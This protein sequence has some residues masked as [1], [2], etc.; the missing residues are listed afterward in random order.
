MNAFGQMMITA[1]TL[2]DAVEPH[3]IWKRLFCSMMVAL[4]K[5]ETGLEVGKKG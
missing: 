1:N 4:M 2:Y 3:A 5:K